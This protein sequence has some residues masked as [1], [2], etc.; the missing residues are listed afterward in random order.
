MGDALRS[1]FNSAIAIVF[2]SLAS[3]A[4]YGLVIDEIG[5]GRLF[6]DGLIAILVSTTILLLLVLVMTRQPDKAIFGVFRRQDLV[7]A[8]FAASAAVYAFHI[9][10]PTIVDRSISLYVLSRVDQHNGA[11]LDQMQ[12]GFLDGYVSGYDAVCRRVDEQL[13][14]GNIVYRDGRYVLTPTGKSILRVLRSLAGVLGQ[15]TYFVTH[16]D[17]TQP[18]SYSVGDGQC[19]R[20]TPG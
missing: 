15:T 11:T 18:Y 6:Y 14:S 16:G 7:T 20:E 2:L 13:G 8:V 10:L 17:G 12:S 1:V 19:R 3:L 4:I 5:S 9:T